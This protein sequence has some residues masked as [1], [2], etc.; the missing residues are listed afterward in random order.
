MPSV[1]MSFSGGNSMYFSNIQLYV[2]VLVC[3]GLFP[4]IADSLKNIFSKLSRPI[5]LFSKIAIIALVFIFAWR[6]I[7]SGLRFMLK[8]SVQ[9]RLSSAGIDYSHLPYRMKLS[10]PYIKEAYAVEAGD[11]ILSRPSYQY[12][13]GLI[14]LNNIALPVKNNTVLFKQCVCPDDIKWN[15]N[16]VARAHILPAFTGF[17]SIRGIPGSCGIGVYGETYYSEQYAEPDRILSAREAHE[18]AERDG[19]KNILFYNC[20][21]KEFSDEISS[22]LPIQP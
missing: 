19:F 17:A 14:R 9:V 1:F 4:L 6:E 10:G 8:K 20:T 15:F 22:C 2:S 11:L 3:L 18:R 5:F 7:R 13:T 21:T 16:C 12:L